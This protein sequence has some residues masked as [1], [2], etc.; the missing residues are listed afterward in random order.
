[1]NKPFL[2]IIK[3]EKRFGCNVTPY[4]DLQG[5]YNQPGN[6]MTLKSKMFCVTFKT[7][8]A[9]PSIDYR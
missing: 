9:I 1:M 8:K 2:M 3:K 4:L 7:L 6:E 5:G